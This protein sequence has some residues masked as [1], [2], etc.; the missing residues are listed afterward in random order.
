MS[1]IFIVRARAFFISVVWQCM[2]YEVLLFADGVKIAYERI[3]VCG[4][5]EVYNELYIYAF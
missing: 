4:L 1:D 5:S 2:G 3:F